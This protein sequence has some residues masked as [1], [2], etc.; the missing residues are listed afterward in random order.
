[1]GSAQSA[2]GE[3]CPSPLPRWCLLGERLTHPYPARRGAPHPT[4][5]HRKGSPGLPVLAPRRPALLPAAPGSEP[6]P[7]SSPDGCPPTRARRG[8]EPGP[9]SP[10]PPATASACLRAPLPAREGGSPPREGEERAAHPAAEGRSPRP[11]F[12]STAVRYPQRPGRLAERFV[13]Q[14]RPRAEASLRSTPRNSA[15]RGPHCPASTVTAAILAATPPGARE[16][17]AS[18]RIHSVT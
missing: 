3:A 17:G 7:L 14:Q 15:G 6:N 12:S 4:C 5:C 18:G 8:A 16:A 10:A 1:M 9:G 11:A 13:F 2:S